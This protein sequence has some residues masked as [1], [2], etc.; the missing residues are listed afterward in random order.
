MARAALLHEL[1][2]D[3]AFIAGVPFGAH[4]AQDRLPQ[5]AVL[6]IGDDGFRLQPARFVVDPEEDL[7]PPV[8]HIQV[9][10]RVAAELGERG[11]ALRP[12]AL[13]ADDQL[14]VAD[15]ERFVGEDMLEDQ[16]PQNRRFHRAGKFLIGFG[17]QAGPLDAE[18]RGGV[19]AFLAQ[20][21]DAFVHCSHPFVVR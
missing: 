14:A 7:F 18:S 17:D 20:L 5:R 12:A 4:V 1:G 19:Q 21:A 11:G 6:P 9:F 8:H 13:L 2:E 10:Q 15:P 3:A 16:R